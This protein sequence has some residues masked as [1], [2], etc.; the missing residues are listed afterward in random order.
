MSSALQSN[1][2]CT[3]QHH[4]TSLRSQDT[5]RGVHTRITLVSAYHIDMDMPIGTSHLCLRHPIEPRAVR[6][7]SFK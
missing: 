4:M 1:E 5:R 3:N 2:G 7:L 6:F